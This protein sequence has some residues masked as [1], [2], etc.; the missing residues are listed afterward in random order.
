MQRKVEL[1]SYNRFT[2]PHFPNF[3][4]GP[5]DGS[6]C[7]TLGLDNHPLAGFRYEVD[8]VNT[9]LVEFIDNSY[10][11]PTD[12]LWDFGGTGTSAEKD[13]EHTF[14][15]TYTVCLTVSNAYAS[16]TACREVMLGPVSSV[17]EAGGR[18]RVVMY[19]NPAKDA[20]TVR[21]DEA[22]EG[23]AV[24]NIYNLYGQLTASHQLP[25]GAAGHTFDVAGLPAGIY[26]V[27]LS[28]ENN[29]LFTAKLVIAR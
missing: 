1:P 17:E 5:L 25:A 20:V 10:Y 21:M 18:K 14:P 19:P 7:D 16:D 2:S 28:Q 27:R 12:W 13:P 29:L 3:R 26:L 11:E 15:G 6:P 22:L 24:L 4:L 8:T 9:L 23:N